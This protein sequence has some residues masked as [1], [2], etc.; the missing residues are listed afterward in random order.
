MDILKNLNSRLTI[1]SDLVEIVPG[2]EEDIKEVIEQSPIQL[3]EDYLNFLH[4]ISGSKKS[5]ITFLVDKSDDSTLSISIWSARYS[6]EALEEFSDSISDDEFFDNAWM[7]G[8]DLGDFVYYY[9]EGKEGFGLYRD[10]AGILCI[11]KAE[12][13]ADSL[14]DFLVKGIGIDVALTYPIRKRN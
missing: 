8:D 10:E 2:G 6:L 1:D 13:I 9:A 5:C 11:E 3:P 14:T 4:A 7:I 12:K